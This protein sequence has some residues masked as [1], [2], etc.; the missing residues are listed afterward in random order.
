[1]IIVT[2]LP[3]SGTSMMMQVLKDNG[4]PIIT[5]NEREADEHNK[6]GYYE[7]SPKAAV[8]MLLPHRIK[9]ICMVRNEED[10]IASVEKMLGRKV[11]KEAWKIEKKKLH[12]W[13]KDKDVLYINYTK[14]MKNPDI[15]KQ[16]G[17]NNIESIK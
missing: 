2:G 10:R 3:R 16:Q 14:V 15:L 12:N 8:K 13:L 5:D 11:N 4:Y 6:N 7:V 9:W 17:F 1:M